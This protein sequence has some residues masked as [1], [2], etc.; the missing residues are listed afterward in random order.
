M[1]TRPNRP[2]VIQSADVFVT[3]DGLIYSTD[4]NGRLYVIEFNPRGL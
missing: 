1:D 4:H 3:P 2:H